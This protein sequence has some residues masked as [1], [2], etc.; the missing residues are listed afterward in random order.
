[1]YKEEYQTPGLK[2]QLHHSLSFALLICTH[3]SVIV[4]MNEV[5]LEQCLF[6][7][8]PQ[9][10]LAIIANTLLPCHNQ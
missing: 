6:P 8:K 7:R 5:S 10:I 4:K 9:C 3:P 2:C 1:M